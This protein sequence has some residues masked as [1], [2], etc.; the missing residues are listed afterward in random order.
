MSSLST[1]VN[2]VFASGGPGPHGSLRHI[3]LKRQGAVAT[4]F[5]LYDLLLNGDN[6]KDVSLETGDVIYFR[7]VGPQ[8]AIVGSV[9]VPA[10][11]ELR[12]REN[13]A[14]A[15]SLAGGL[16][17]TAET[18]S[19]EI[20]RTEKKP[21]GG[22]VR[23]AVDVQMDQ[24]SLG[25]VLRD[26]DIVRV[27]EE[28][29]RF[30]K[31]V[32]LRGNVATP[33]RFAWREGMRVRDL[34]PTKESLLT[35]DYWLRREQ[36][37]LPVDDFQ[38]MMPPVKMEIPSNQPGQTVN[39]PALPQDAQTINSGLFPQLTAGVPQDNNVPQPGNS[40]QFQSLAASNDQEA[41]STGGSQ[42]KSRRSPDLRMKRWARAR[43][44]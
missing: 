20:E 40:E 25:T 27:R 39:R 29:P 3:L 11:Y 41:G 9:N 31:T 42:V 8:V 2:A 34:I 44:W 1:L 19:L 21:N 37:G 32:T 35:P 7:A 24:P 15:L 12:G 14:E 43:I 38:P 36:L 17:A 33:G 16:S 30:E 22:S 18:S 23:V 5:D 4:D 28:A 6:S 10:I 13:I 26:A